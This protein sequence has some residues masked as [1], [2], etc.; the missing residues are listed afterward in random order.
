M[1][2]QIENPLKKYYR[3]PQLYIKLPSRGEWWPEGSLSK[4]VTNEYPVFAMTARDE[5]ALKTPDALLNGQ[6]TV[7]VIQ[8]CVPNIKDAW[9]TPI[10]DIDH[11][12]IAIRLATYGNAMDFT[13]LC[14]HCKH[15]NEHTLDLQLL[16]DKYNTLPSWNKTLQV[17]DLTISLKPESY[18]TFNNKSIKT[19]EEQ[20]VIQMINQE[21]LSEAEKLEKFKEMFKK[22][23]QLT[24]EQV[25]GNINYIKLDAQTV[26]DNHAFINDFFQNCDRDI[27]NT[28]NDAIA[29]IKSNT[30]TN[31]IDLQ[32]ESCTKEYQTPL[33]FEMSNFF[34]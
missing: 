31:K 23:L 30:P 24:V 9:H 29:E 28:V 7:D 16:L 19:F 8:S 25:A 22:L 33:V 27:W 2:E 14:P 34:G 26:V 21:S 11:I 5:L 1:N 20:R 32:C 10:C 17:K 15:K 3:Q 6:S 12:L 18:K 13:S 4:T